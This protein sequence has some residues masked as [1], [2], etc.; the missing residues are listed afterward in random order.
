MEGRG[1]TLL[2]LSADTK[3]SWV[4]DGHLL[5]KGN[6]SLD[7]IEY[8]TGRTANL[9]NEKETHAKAVLIHIQRNDI[10]L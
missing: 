9:F 4:D 10:E 1:L 8:K 3:L 6:D 7:I 5:A 2:P